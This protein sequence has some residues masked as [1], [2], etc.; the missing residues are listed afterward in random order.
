MKNKL[1]C[2]FA[3]LAVFL[4]ILNAAAADY[5]FE[6]PNSATYVMLEPDGSMSIDVEYT[7]KNLGQKL[8]YIDIGLPNDNYTLSSISVWLN[9]EQN[10]RIKVTKAD[11]EE[12]GLRH[13]ITL[14][15]GS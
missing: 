3:A 2:I 14:E 9:G 7:F 8:D 12:S 4:V 15:M 11:Y 5:S 1:I 6:V 10:S 13:G